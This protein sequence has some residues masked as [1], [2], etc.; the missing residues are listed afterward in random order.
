MAEA[1]KL[2]GCGTRV[3][4]GLADVA[5]EHHSDGYAFTSGLQTCG[6]AW[7][8]PICSFKIRVKR[9][10]EIALAIAGHRAIGGTVLLLTLTTQHSTGELLDDVWS[11]VQ[12]AWGYITAH[13]RYRSSVTN[14]ASGSSAPSKSRT[15]ST[16]G[17]PTCTCCCSSTPRSTPSTHPTST[18]RSPSLPRPVGATHGSQA[19]P[20]RALIGRCGST[21][22]QGRRRRRRWHVLHQSRLGG[23][24]GGW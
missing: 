3:R 23:R 14:W 2:V 13:S 7:S 4:H 16:A 10:A 24:L 6:S 21:P 22:G 12:D 17:T 18:G 1:S 20:R 5:V 9:S 11:A 8:C 15:E 19:L